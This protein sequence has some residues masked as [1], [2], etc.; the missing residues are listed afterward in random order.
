MALEVIGSLLHNKTQQLW[1]ETLDEARKA[2]PED[3]F[4]N[5]KTSYDALSCKQKQI[6][7]D[8]AWVP[9]SEREMRPL[10]ESRK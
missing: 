4:G 10:Q 3:V 6:F 2:P 9:S 5:L 8:I 1:E 7:L